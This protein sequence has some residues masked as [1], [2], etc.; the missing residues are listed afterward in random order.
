MK[1]AIEGIGENSHLKRHWLKRLGAAFIDWLIATSAA[2]VFMY[3]RNCITP[4]NTVILTGIIWY[5]LAV[6]TEARLGYTPGKYILGFHVVSFWELMSLKKSLIRN[7]P[8]LLWFVWLPLDTIIGM[9]MEGDPRQR[10]SD[11]VSRT[12]VIMRGE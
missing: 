2:W 5:A 4:F 11:H 6:I 1:T 7:I 9:L 8:K 12:C 3:L 10:L